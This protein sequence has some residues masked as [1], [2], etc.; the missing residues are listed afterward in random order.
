MSVRTLT[1]GLSL[2]RRNVC[3]AT[4]STGRGVITRLAAMLLLSCWHE[5]V[6]KDLLNTSARKC[7]NCQ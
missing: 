2:I 1:S 3:L 5:E 6:Q 4:E 7:I